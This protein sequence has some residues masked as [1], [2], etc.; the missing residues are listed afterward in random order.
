M[1]WER[2][3]SCSGGPGVRRGGVA[4]CDLTAVGSCPATVWGWE[5]PPLVRPAPGH[6]PGLPGKEGVRW[7]AVP[8]FLGVNFV[9][10]GD[11]TFFCAR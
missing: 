3:D 10:D 11:K 1:S 2:L 4:V 9:S 7:P 5:R 8:E 6:T